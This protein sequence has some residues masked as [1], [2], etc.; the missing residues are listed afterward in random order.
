M[1]GVYV[2]DILFAGAGTMWDQSVAAIKQKYTWSEW[3]CGVFDQCG[4][5]VVQKADMSLE[6]T[7]AEYISAVNEITVPARGVPLEQ[8]ATPQQVSQ[9]RALIGSLQWRGTQ[10][11]PLA[12]TASSQLASQVQGATVQTLRAANTALKKAKA[13]SHHRMI[14]R[15]FE[16]QAQPVPYTHLTLPTNFPLSDPGLPVIVYK[17][18]QTKKT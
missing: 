10:T 4:V 14:V 7:Q 12:L 8:P 5:H 18:K 17:N 9:L 13:R 6:L 11:D 15:S 2:D 1:I 16:R 3:Q